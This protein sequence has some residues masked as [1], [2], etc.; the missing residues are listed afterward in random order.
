M[1]KRDIAIL[2]SP[3]IVFVLI[4]A[5]ACFTSGMIRERTRDDGSQQKFDNFISNVQSGKWRLTTGQWLE[6][7]WHERVLGDAYRNVAMSSA[8]VMRAFILASL[9]GFLLQVT[10]VFVVR[11][12][13]KKT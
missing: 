8:D 12:R 9:L 6:G 3:A 13:L 4:L 10:A 1:T 11:N 5:A 2:L 7:M